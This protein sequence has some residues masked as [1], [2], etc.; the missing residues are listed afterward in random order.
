MA[1][2]NAEQANLVRMILAAENKFRDLAL[3]NTAIDTMLRSSDL[4]SL[5]VND[6]TDHE[7]RIIEEINIRQQKTKKEWR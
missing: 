2:F 5:K 6:I 1:P 3:F 7:G 4:L